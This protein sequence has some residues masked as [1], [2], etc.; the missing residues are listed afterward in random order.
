MPMYHGPCCCPSHPPSCGKIC[1]RCVVTSQMY[2]REGRCAWLCRTIPTC[3]PFKTLW[4]RDDPPFQQIATFG[5]RRSWCEYLKDHLRLSATMI[6]TSIYPFVDRITEEP[7]KWACG[8]RKSGG[9]SS[10]TQLPSMLSRPHGLR[11]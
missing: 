6:A 4:H 11:R 8:W 5:G 1:F 3:A 9:A 2:R 7:T 10:P